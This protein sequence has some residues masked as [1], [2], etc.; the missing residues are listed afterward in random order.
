MAARTLPR[1]G[2]SAHGRKVRNWLSKT[3]TSLLVGLL[4]AGLGVAAFA[5]EGIRTSD[6]HLDN[7]SLYVVNRDMGLVGVLNTQ[8]DDLVASSSIA[9]A[10][11]RI[12]QENNTV[13]VHSQVAGQLQRF[14]PIDNTMGS[15]QSVPRNAQISMD[16]DAVVVAN[17]DNGKV[18]VS[19]VDE[20][21]ST[22]Y[23]GAQADLDIGESG[24]AV[25]TTGGEH[26]G[27][28][29]ADSTLL[30][31]DEATRL[32]FD[33][34]KDADVD[35]SSLG[36]KGVVL[37]RSSGQ[38]WVEGN[39]RVSQ[40]DGASAAQLLEPSQELSFD[41]KRADAVFANRAG[42]NMRTSDG[43]VVSLSGPMENGAPIRPIEEA[44]CV[45]GAVGAF[46]VKRCQDWDEGQ[47]QPIPE[48][49]DEAELAFV[50]NR[51]SVV[52]QDLKSGMIWLV[53]KDMKIIR[54]WSKVAPKKDEGDDPKTTTDSLVEPERDENNRPPVAVDDRLLA[55]AGRSTVLTVLDND[56][57]PDGDILTIAAPATAGNA[58]LSLLSGGS[59]LQITI[60]ANPQPSYAFSYTVSD[61]RGGSDTA[62]VT[63]STLPADQKAQNNKPVQLKGLRPVPLAQ[64]G[65]VTKNILQ[66][67]RDPDGDDLILVGAEPTDAVGDEVVFT[68][69]GNVTY[70]DVGKS[71]GDKK[72]KVTVSDGLVTEVG[73][74]VLEVK[75]RGTVPPVANADFYATRPVTVDA[76]GRE[77]DGEIKIYPLANDIGENLQL[78]GVDKSGADF[79]TQPNFKDK[80]FTFKA[81][82]A[83][84]YYVQYQ[85]SNGVPAT[86]LVR[87]DVSGSPT[88][89]RPP[90]AARD[91]A[92]LPPD[93][94]VLIDPL[95]NDIDPDGDVL[96]VQSVSE[97]PRLSIAMQ[98]R[99][100]LTVK[101]VNV[102][103]EPI[104]LT[105]RVSDGT[106]SVPGTIMIIPA[107]M[108][109]DQ[110]PKAVNDEV[111][112]RAG[113]TASVNVLDNDSSPIGA[114]LKL[115]KIVEGSS[116][117]W[118]DDDKIRVTVPAGATGSFG[119]QYQITD[120]TNQTAA[121]FLNVRVVS[122][123]AENTPPSPTLVEARAISNTVTRIYIPLE[124]IDDTGDPV[125][126]LGIASGPSQGRI[127]ATGDQWF[128]YQSYANSAGTD[129]F[130]YQVAD[131][132]G[133]LGEADIRVGIAPASA[134]NHPPTGVDDFITVRPDRAVRMPVL[135]NDHD[136][137]GD[138]FGF[139]D[140]GAVDL[141]D[142][143]ADVAGE[144]ATD[145]TFT[146]PSTPGEYPGRYYVQD[147]RG[148][149]GAGN[150][151]ITVDPDAD[152]LPP[153][154][155]DDHIDISEIT[156]AKNDWIEV[157]VLANDFDQDGETL[158]LSVPKAD[159]SSGRAAQ[160]NP[161]Q[162]TLKLPIEDT[163]Q[164]IEY[165]I[166]DEDGLSASAIVTVPGRNDVVPVLR[167]PNLSFEAIA[168]QPL[169]LDLNAIIAGTNNRKVKLTDVMNLYATNGQAA[170]PAEDKV[171]FT[172]VHGYEG[173]ASLV[174]QVSDVM[175]TGQR[176]GKTA[177]FTIPFT[178]KRPPDVQVSD[179]EDVP[180]AN[181]PPE[182]P[183][184]V[185][186]SVGQ[187]EDPIRLEVAP[188]Y[189]DPNGSKLSFDEW[190]V[191]S[192]AANMSW[193]PEVGNVA[194]HVQAPFGPD[195]GSK[196]VLRGRVSDPN[197]AALD[198]RVILTAATSTRPVIT[199]TNDI[200]ADA[201][202]GRTD[203]VDVVSNDRSYLSDPVVRLVSIGQVS[204]GTAKV[205]DDRHVQF[206][207][208]AGAAGTMK[209]QYYVQDATKDPNRQVQG[210]VEVRVKS[211]PG[212]PGTPRI[213]SVGDERVSF[214]Y[215][216]GNANN[217]PIDQREVKAVSGDM[218]RTG[219]CDVEA[220]SI[221]GLVNARPWTISVRDHN[222]VGWGPWSPA[223]ASFIPD[224]VPEKMSAP[225]VDWGDG[226][227]TI[228]WGKGTSRGSAITTYKV[229]ILDETAKVVETAQPV[230]KWTG[231]KNG[232]SYRFRVAAVNRAGVGE[233][234]E[235]SVAQHPSGPPSAPTAID[236][237][238]AG[239]L[240]GQAIRVK[241]KA[242]SSWGGDKPGE[243]V[244]Q[245]STG[246]EP[247]KTE[248]V[249]GTDK[250]IVGLKNG[251]K[252][253]ISVTAVNSRRQQSD[254]SKFAGEV[255][256]FTVPSVENFRLVPGDGVAVVSDD[257]KVAGKHPNG[258]ITV[259]VNIVVD[260]GPNPEPVTF[261]PNQLPYI[262]KNIP[263]G[264]PYQ[265]TLTA[266]IKVGRAN[267][268]CGQAISS[269]AKVMSVGQP[270]PP[271][272]VTDLGVT[273]S[274]FRSWRIHPIDS[275]KF[276]GGTPQDFAYYYRAE[277]KGTP[278]PVTSGQRIFS[279]SPGSSSG[280]RVGILNTAIS[281]D[282]ADI[283]WSNQVL[284]N[285]PALVAKI[286]EGRREM[287]V[288][289][290]NL[291]S[292]DD[293]EKW[294]T[295]TCSTSRSN[296]VNVEPDQYDRSGSTAPGS[297]IRIGNL[298]LD[299]EADFTVVCEAAPSKGEKRRW[300]TEVK[301]RP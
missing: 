193:M 64:S 247:A 52:L 153:I 89:N 282:I 3:W 55:R 54:D 290:R 257:L 204:G 163:M 207:P 63:V 291:F 40:I 45:Y 107:P 68:P 127:V 222:E 122:P 161:E 31:G 152:P 221:T 233:M 268:K 72:V 254:A 125:R 241:W 231:L 149:K 298:S 98:D 283:Q 126:L 146:S 113:S 49:P 8:I 280:V 141:K 270:S 119:I 102:G 139:P 25:A 36:G 116:R 53:N 255:V 145:I 248:S 117:A 234:S 263:N 58:T 192:N 173:P 297:P 79:T 181:L 188:L 20:A 194:L 66:D 171:S 186:F 288:E 281:K 86:G 83:G 278:E 220:C 210:F 38:L 42:L 218:T 199:T 265:G 175:P 33:L 27:L 151:V 269:G 253:N 5:H 225:E 235:P 112:V 252:Y 228:R 2:D 9:T 130:R 266:C 216:S 287:V 201:Y 262:I 183:A 190:K 158:E 100:L 191:E 14:N 279:L 133:A 77:S 240:N 75:K 123:D 78:A 120:S 135:W 213:Q 239:Y 187:G 197:G 103:T 90:V 155:R 111:A 18:F 6:L 284:P 205:L 61:G 259:T 37:V 176:G 101:G 159:Q 229:Q 62:R 93:G 80:S 88:E 166:T 261:S 22:D 121:A 129:R 174:F 12:M 143:D 26:L 19:S 96:V 108:I 13:L 132:L 299:E 195:L 202:A 200:V 267:P 217:A 219:K 179:Q 165:T 286:D 91:M 170:S 276:N 17:P 81:T 28:S 249:R 272:D 196:M 109:G 168:G 10:D 154:A 50:S 35:F 147:E 212:Q 142:I 39:Q 256:P 294:K 264:K 167:D 16:S 223:S 208:T 92:L 301:W 84:T 74:W 43:S 60:P 271:D 251:S 273:N 206:T 182:G 21:L 260:G 237:Y 82:K 4:A 48:L 236:A 226:E 51:G 156:K 296:K 157:D 185:N 227:L 246:N 67:W 65:S 23:Q 73:Y 292:P 244:V 162:G 76:N 44:G 131:S 70:T 57:D 189:R 47:I 138:R 99:H 97:D 150:V 11:F 209:I 69:D 295:F 238:D 258:S 105:Y 232:T 224:V 46:V 32:P 24:R 29:L 34:D 59:G 137:D 15:I 106:T 214:T 1:R 215:T 275:V 203:K 115:T 178:V 245:W 124:G 172:G 250:T 87:I 104:A 128:D 85:V 230:F 148:A 110:R 56:S 177:F 211:A 41:G 144:P 243:Y 285:Y 114:D 160:V 169:D 71:T 136:V 289:M 30:R 242:P 300:S 95:I 118:I 180:L 7:G 94:K 274:G 134:D 164:Q 184:E 277:P 198:I 140:E 293:P